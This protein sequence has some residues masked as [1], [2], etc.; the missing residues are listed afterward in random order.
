MVSIIKI[1]I[2]SMPVDFIIKNIYE[3]ILSFYHNLYISGSCYAWDDG[4]KLVHQ[5]ATCKPFTQTKKSHEIKITNLLRPRIKQWLS[6]Q[7]RTTV[8][9]YTY[10]LEEAANVSLHFVMLLWLYHFGPHIILLVRL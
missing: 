5:Q 1:Q 2:I 9:V 10:I 4:M 7:Y 8:H 6:P 3:L